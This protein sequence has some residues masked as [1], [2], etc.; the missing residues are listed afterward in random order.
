MYVVDEEMAEPLA[1]TRVHRILCVDDEPAVL[2]ALRRAFR[3]EPYEVVTTDN[4]ELALELLEEATFSLILLDQRMP[5]MTGTDLAER[6]RRRSPNSVR[7]LLT[8]YPALA[9]VR[10]GLAGDVE[11]LLGKPWN[12]DVL[13]LTVRRLLR[14]LER[15]ANDN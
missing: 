6:A 1:L 5:G 3:G 2:A 4:P 9:Q 10:H 15:K 12:D 11:W 14:D 7:V 13:R 8:A